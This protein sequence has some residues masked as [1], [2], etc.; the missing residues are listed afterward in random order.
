LETDLNLVD[1]TC[2]DQ[3]SLDQALHDLEVDVFDL[4]DVQRQQKEAEDA[5]AKAVI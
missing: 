4:E 3:E 5:E 2:P 1:P